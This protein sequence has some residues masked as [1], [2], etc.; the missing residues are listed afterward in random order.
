VLLADEIRVPLNL[1]AFPVLRGIVWYCKL[2]DNSIF[3]TKNAG[4]YYY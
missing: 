3:F 4:S 1:S 2:M